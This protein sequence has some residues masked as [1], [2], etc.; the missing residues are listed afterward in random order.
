MT[1]VSIP[2]GSQVIQLE[3]PD[4]NFLMNAIPKEIPGIPNP[5]IELEKSLEKPIKTRP[6]RE[7]AKGK[8]KVVIVVDD[9]TRPLPSHLLLPTIL[10]E[11]QNAGVRQDG[12]T[13]LFATGLHRPVTEEE[14]KRLLGEDIA[15]RYRWL[16]HNADAEDLVYYG[17]TKR[18]TPIYINRLYAEA[19]L[20]ILVGDVTLHYYAGFGGGGKSIL[21]GISG[22]E[23][24]IRNHSMLFQPNARPGIC[25]GNPVCEDISEAAKKVGADFVINVVL[26]TRKE[27]VRIFAGELEDVFKKGIE[28]VRRMYIVDVPQKADITIVSPG[29]HPFDINLYQSHKGLFFAEQATR[30]NGSIILLAACPEGAGNKLFE[31]SMRATKNLAPD[32]AMKMLMD[33][34]CRSFSVGIH[35][36][37][38]LIRATSRY[39]IF[40]KT[41]MDSREISEIYRMTPISDP[42]ATLDELL[43]RNPEA[44]V[45]V[46]PYG[47]E[48]LPIVK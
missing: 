27:I 5:S 3:I 32:A 18:G 8:R 38:Y 16:S 21:P 30:D 26:N 14:A 11:L 34:L 36:A 17:E 46:L 1:K 9:A 41:E 33:E 22:R 24:I 25:E 6:L 29:G 12:I 47:N 4:D 37:Y 19:D 39:S 45:L 10:N 15:E 2:Y 44:K 7:L 23:T 48:T 20:R 42:Q 13:I 43:R 40:I 35:K 28:L 31:D